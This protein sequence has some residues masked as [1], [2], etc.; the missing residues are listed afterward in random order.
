M[1]SVHRTKSETKWFVIHIQYLR[2]E[3]MMHVNPLKT[4]F[5]LWQNTLNKEPSTKT[6]VACKGLAV[7]KPNIRQDQETRT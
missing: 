5:P 4:R 7:C 3:L 2:V 6:A 1:C